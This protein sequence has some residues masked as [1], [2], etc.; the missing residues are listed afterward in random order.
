MIEHPGDSLGK[1]SDQIKASYLAKWK[2]FRELQKQTD[3]KSQFEAGEIFGDVLMEV[4][5]LILTVMSVA[6]AAAKLAAKVPQLV[7]IAEFIRGA[8]AAEAGGVTEEAA[9]AA[10]GASKATQQISQEPPTPLPPASFEPGL[11]KVVGSYDAMNPGP[12]PDN[13]AGTFSGGRYRAV[14]LEQDTVLHRAGEGTKP[15]GQFYDRSPA[16]SAIKT[17]IDKAVLPE[18]PGGGRSPIDSSIAM[19]I[20]KGTTVYV[21]EVSSQ[22]GAFVGGTEQIVVQQPWLIPGAQPVSITPIP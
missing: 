8:R 2:R 10:K 13:L 12:L 11:G 20:P 7:R 9:E 4:V 6:G 21:G 18:W 17:R 14:V 5:M 19:K 15:F 22:G 1:M 16:E 3:L